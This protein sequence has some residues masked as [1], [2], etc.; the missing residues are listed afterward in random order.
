MMMKCIYLGLMFKSLALSRIKALR[1]LVGQ[2]LVSG[3]VFL[4]N[5]SSADHVR[6]TLVAAMQP[7]HNVE[8]Y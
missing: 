5:G 4:G 1:G 8:Q 3:R 6:T 2:I 7:H